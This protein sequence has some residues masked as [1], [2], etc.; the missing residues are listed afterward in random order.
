MSVA[1]FNALTDGYVTAPAPVGD[2]AGTN[3]GATMGASMGPW[4]GGGS[5]ADVQGVPPL[6]GSHNTPL[7]VAFLGLAALAVVILLRFLGFRFSGTASV[8]R[9]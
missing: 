4:V 7:Q 1:A 5:A 9:G 8:G 3:S 6:S 2:L